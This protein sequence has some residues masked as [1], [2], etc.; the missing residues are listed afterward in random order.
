LL[1]SLREKILSKKRTWQV[2][3]FGDDTLYALEIDLAG[4][5]ARELTNTKTTGEIER[6]S[7]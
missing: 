6:C 5:L 1:Y 2:F 7:A 4:A 3:P